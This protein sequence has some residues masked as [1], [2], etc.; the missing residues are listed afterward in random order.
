M[1][2]VTYSA[3]NPYTNNRPWV[4]IQ[5]NPGGSSPTLKCLVDTGADYLQINQAD[6]TAAGISLVGATPCRV[7]TVAGV[8]T[9]YRVS[10]VRVSI[11]GSTP[12]TVDVL[13]DAS[14][15]T[16]PLPAG[17]QVMLVAFDL[18][19]NTSEWLRT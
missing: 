16:K 7:R 8:V 5:L 4:D 15:S 17:R 1:S 3:Q 11:D 2:T 18:G 14:N 10:N 19:F 6:A 12:K 9:L 13:V